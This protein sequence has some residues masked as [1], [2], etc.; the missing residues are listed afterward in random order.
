M[1]LRIQTFKMFL[2]AQTLPITLQ[3]WMKASFCF[4]TGFE[5]DFSTYLLYLPVHYD[6]ITFHH[7]V[8][9]SA[10]PKKKLVTA[11]ILFSADI[12]KLTMEENPGSRVPHSSYG[13]RSSSMLFGQCFHCF[14]GKMFIKC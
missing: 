14:E 9:S 8:S 4:I 12:R 7:R 11:Y 2:P 10:D 13:S 3:H 6:Y 1:M 5:K